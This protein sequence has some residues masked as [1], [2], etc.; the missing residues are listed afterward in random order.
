[1]IAAAQDQALRTDTFKAKIE[2]RPV[3]LSPL[4]RMCS[5]KGETLVHLLCECS[6]KARLQ[7]K[8]RHDNVVKVYPRKSRNN[9]DWSL[10]RNR[11]EP[12][13]ECADIKI[14]WDLTIQM[15]EEIEAQKLN[16]TQYR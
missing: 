6:K 4:S 2:K 1:M 12:V 10:N 7:H 3:S 9:V 8:H 16:P 5:V 11:P 14:L 15:D 13:D